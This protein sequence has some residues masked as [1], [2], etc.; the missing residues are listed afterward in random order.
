[1]FLLENLG[2]IVNGK[3]IHPEPHP[4]NPIPRDD[5]KFTVNG[6]ET[7]RGEIRK[8]I[9]EAHHLL[10]LNSPS[11]QQL[12]QLLGKLNATTPALQMA[13][14]FCRS[15]QVCLKQAL[16]ANQQNYQTMV[17]LSPQARED[18]QWW[19]LHLTSWNGRSL[20]TQAASMTVTS[21]AS[22]QGWGATCNGSRTRGP[23][24]PSEQ[25][26]HIN[27]LELY[28]HLQRRNQASQFSCNWTTLQ[29]LPTSTGGGE[30]HRQLCLS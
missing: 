1:M 18:L 26:L 28:R 2:F 10:S 14:L 29:Q 4:G 17:Q 8:I 25:S 13:P 16:S 12:S 23:R 3:K 21:D 6:P 11:A 22:L 24:S 5:S 27:C 7:P 20:I 15:L 30:Q 9:Q 19:E